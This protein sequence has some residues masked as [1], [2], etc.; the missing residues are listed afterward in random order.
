MS[1][2]TSV[3]D[4]LRKRQTL[5][6][7]ADAQVGDDKKD[8]VP[9]LLDDSAKVDRHNKSKAALEVPNGLQNWIVPLILTIA[10]IFTRTYK[11][12]WADFVVWDE[13]HFGK[14]ASHYLQHEFYHDVHPPL[15]KMMLGFSGLLAGYNGTFP[16]ES[17]AKYPPELNYGIMRMFCALMGAAMVP[18]AYFTG[19]QLR[20]SKLASIFLALLVLGETTYIA[21]TKFILLDSPLLFFTSLSCYCL[22][23]F[24]N[25]NLAQP[26]SSNWYFWLA[27]T[28]LSIGCTASVK[29][30]GFFLIAFV[31]LH[32]IEDLWELWGDR[33]LSLAKYTQHWIARI[34]LLI[35]VPVAVYMASFYVHFAI[36]YKSGTG[37]ATLSSLFQAHLEGINFNDNPLEIA[38]GSLVTFKNNGAG[39]GLLHSHVQRYPSGSEQQQVTTYSHKDSN[40]EFIITKNWDLHKQ[41]V[42]REESTANL[43]IEFLKDGDIIR[44]VHDQTLKNLHS[45]NHPAPI[46]VHDTEVSCYGNA[47]HGDNNDHWRIEVVDD[48]HVKKITKVRSLTTRFRIRHVQSGCLLRAD[49]VTLPEWGFKQTE[50]TCQKQPT[51]DKSRSNIWNVELHR[52]DRLP[53]GT[54]GQFKPSFMRDFMDL[55]VAMWTT[56]NALTP[57]KDKEPDAL[58]S[59]PWEWPLQRV[60]LRMC[61]WGDHEI[62]FYLIGHPLGWLG[63]TASLALFLVSLFIY[64]IRSKRMAN[65]WKNPGEWD[66]FW[67]AG[68]VGLFGWF[69]HYFP[70]YIMGRVMYLHHYFPA[71]YFGLIMLALMVDHLS[72]RVGKTMN[73]LVLITLCVVTLVIF[74]YFSPFAFGFTG[75]ANQMRGRRWFKTWNMFDGE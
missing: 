45:H 9:P 44:I 72:A 52:N 26:F 32:T 47:T 28:G 43:P 11:I 48:V 8:S 33:K 31:G 69:F 13:A 15:G 57:D 10:A 14:F 38:Y 63:S 24:R 60:G 59:Q 5:P 4:G 1:S 29:W 54:K 74:Y 51:D 2:A 36:L 23:V 27:M 65:D 58:T 46:T 66:N 6:I 71:L 70:F 73:R 68:K 35:V 16:F 7:A 18:L 64:A 67:F 20:L 75:P 40:N 21:I 37:D 19:I 3:A 12:S 53:P 39:G 61:G 30:V 49:G 25:Y 55:N 22:C 41:M 50:V 62:K 17:G 56:N 42:E 34:A